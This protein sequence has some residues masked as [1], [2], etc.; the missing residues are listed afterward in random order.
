MPMI[1]RFKSDQQPSIPFVCVVPTTYSPAVADNV[2]S[3]GAAEVA[4]AAM[5]VGRDVRGRRDYSMGEAVEGAVSVRSTTVATT[6]PPRSSAPITAT[7]PD[8]PGPFLGSPL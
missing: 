5:L 6:L 8:V 2:M 3:K 7:L 4:V 1:W